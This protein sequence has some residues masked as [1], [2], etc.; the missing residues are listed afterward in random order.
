MFPWD[1]KVNDGEAINTFEVN[2]LPKKV[3]PGD[4]LVL[5]PIDSETGAANWS[6]Q[7]VITLKWDNC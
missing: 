2:K 6:N 4:L 5:I 1:E 3:K 7:L